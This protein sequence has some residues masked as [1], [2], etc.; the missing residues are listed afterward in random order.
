MWQHRVIR[1]LQHTCALPRSA[2]GPGECDDPGVGEAYGD[3]ELINII[4][5]VEQGDEKDPKR[6]SPKSQ[7]GGGCGGPGD[8]EGERDGKAIADHSVHDVHRGGAHLE[9]RWGCG[10]GEGEVLVIIL[11]TRQGHPGDGPQEWSGGCSGSW[12]HGDC[13]GGDRSEGGGGRQCEGD[14]DPNDVT[15]CAPYGV[16]IFK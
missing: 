2:V 11:R 5:R 4:R 16:G 8:G 7:R 14:V 10:G 12:R 9:E 3:V 1:H 15:K 13:D 6:W